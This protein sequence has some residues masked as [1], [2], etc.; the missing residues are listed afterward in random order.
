[1]KVSQIMTAAA[2]TNQPGETLTQ[3]ARKM[4]EQQ[5]GSLLVIEGEDQLAGIITERDIL[6]AVAVGADLS[7]VTIADVMAKEPLTVHP[8]STLREAA[9][10][11]TEHW[12]RHLPVVDSGKLVGIVSQRD[13]S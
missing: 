3:A 7:T 9:K 6:K 2:I 11:M 4:W 12:I 10:I 5:T 13:L 1:M 8:G